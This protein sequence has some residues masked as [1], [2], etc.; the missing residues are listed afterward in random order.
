MRVAGESP[1]C[2]VG[3]GCATVQQSGYSEIAGVPVAGLGVLAYALLLASAAVPGAGSRLAGLF[4]ALVGVGLS[5]WLTYV[6]L[7]VIGAVC[8]WCVASAVTMALS[9]LAAIARIRI[10]E[11]VATPAG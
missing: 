2:V 4:T 1:A 8:P 5:A 11:A 9:A 3:N 10:P 7:A 6:E